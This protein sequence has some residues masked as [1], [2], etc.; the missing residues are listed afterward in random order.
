VRST[1]SDDVPMS[2]THSSSD[3]TEHATNA[4]HWRYVVDSSRIVALASIFVVVVGQGGTEIG[5][6]LPSVRAFLLG[7][8]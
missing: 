2:P 5:I 6:Q 7:S 1:V 8:A 4:K 3:Q